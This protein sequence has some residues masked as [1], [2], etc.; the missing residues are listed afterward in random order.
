[1]KTTT[2][3]GHLTEHFGTSAENL[4]TESL[5]FVLRNSPIAS[6]AFIDFLLL[7]GVFATHSRRLRIRTI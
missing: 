7:A 3:L 6:N 1:M 2:L 4:A 5:C